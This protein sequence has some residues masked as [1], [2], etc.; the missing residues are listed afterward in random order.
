MAK[1]EKIDKVWVKYIPRPGH[2]DRRIIGG[3]MFNSDP[4]LEQSKLGDL[5]DADFVDRYRKEL[6]DVGCIIFDGPGLDQATSSYRKGLKRQGRKAA[7]E[8]QD[9][10]TDAVQKTTAMTEDEQ[11]A[12]LER[13]EAEARL[14]G[15]A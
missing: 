12:E 6:V 11:L 1:E 7:R 15:M 2:P 14:R 8:V 10:V 5:L 3:R 13:I 9:A 4:R